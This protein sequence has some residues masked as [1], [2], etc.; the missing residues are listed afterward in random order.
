MV[1]N[2]RHVKTIKY[3]FYKISMI[4]NNEPTQVSTLKIHAIA[5]LQYERDSK[6]PI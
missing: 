1:P 5:C 3:W 4:S 2:S 6:G